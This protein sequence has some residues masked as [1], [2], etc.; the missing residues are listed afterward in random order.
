[1]PQNNTITSLELDCNSFTGE[2]IHILAGFMH[3]CPCLQCLYS[4]N[5]GIT[6]DDLKQL[7]DKLSQL[8]S[9][10]PSLCSKLEEWY[11]DNNEI[12][13]SGV[14][15][16]KDQITP[17]LPRLYHLGLLDDVIDHS[18]NPVSSEMEETLNEELRRR[19][20][21]EVSCYVNQF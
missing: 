17:L 7:L 1:M 21:H 6:S 12:D 15:A 5:C 10:S 4:R 11:L 3:L 19:R 18:N 16:L 2:G 9:S 20:C 14:L 13:D 8:K